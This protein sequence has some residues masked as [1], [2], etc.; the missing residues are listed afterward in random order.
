V[1]AYQTGGII[2]DSQRAFGVFT[3]N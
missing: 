3:S 1:V 2:K